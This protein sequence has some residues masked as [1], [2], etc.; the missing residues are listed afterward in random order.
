MTVATTFLLIQAEEAKVAER[1]RARK[2]EEDEKK[3]AYVEKALIVGR[4]VKELIVE[5]HGDDGT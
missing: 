2:K 5:M 4:E 3:Q 1:V